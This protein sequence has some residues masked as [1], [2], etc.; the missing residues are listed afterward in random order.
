[1]RRARR[2]LSLALLGA[3]LAVAA[4]CTQGGGSTPVPAASQA[5]AASV[6]PEASA[7]A[8]MAPTPSGSDAKGSY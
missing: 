6:A 2:T 5:P 1:M 7:P 8:S 4:A 3:I